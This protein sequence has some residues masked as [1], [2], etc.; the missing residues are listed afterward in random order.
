MKLVTILLALGLAAWCVVLPARSLA[1]SLE[2]GTLELETSVGLDHTSYSS[3]SAPQGTITRFDGAV[4]AGYSVTRLLQVGGALLF[5]HYSSVD[6]PNEDPFSASSY[7]A[8]AD[9]TLN[10]PTP[11]N[12]VPYLRLGLGAETFSGD[13]AEDAKVALW[14]PMVRAGVRVLVG[15]SGSVNLSLAYRHESNSGGV[16]KLAANRLGFAVGLS[17]FPVRGK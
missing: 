7:G 15:E 14:A 9:V 16:E 10:F 6:L 17:L 3:A 5:S 4:G 2:A 1:A 11:N 12:L 13:G 8:S